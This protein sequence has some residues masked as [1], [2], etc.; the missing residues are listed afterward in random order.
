M[1]STRPVRRLG[2]QDHSEGALTER[3]IFERVAVMVAVALIATAWADPAVTQQ[4]ASP[5]QPWHAPRNSRGVQ[6]PLVLQLPP[7]NFGTLSAT[8]PRLQ[9]RPD[10]N[11]GCAPQWPCRLQLFGIIQKN[12]GVGLKG[13]ALTW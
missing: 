3:I 5:S 2:R 8:S 12:G 4:V 7:A 11:T 13:I 9:A 10:Q 1:T 6:T